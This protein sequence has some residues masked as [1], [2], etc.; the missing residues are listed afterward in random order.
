[1]LKSIKYRTVLTHFP[2]P[3]FVKPLLL[4]VGLV[5]IIVLPPPP[6]L[7]IPSPHCPPPA[8]IIQLILQAAADGASPEPN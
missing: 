2:L 5:V 4:F 3:F 7:L 1:M 6:P 8:I